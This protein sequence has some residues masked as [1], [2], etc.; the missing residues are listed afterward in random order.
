V[1]KG[2]RSDHLD[3]SYRGYRI[4]G[5]G[6]TRPVHPD[7]DQFTGVGPELRAVPFP[8]EQTAVPEWSALSLGKSLFR[9]VEKVGINRMHPGDS[10][11]PGEA[12]CESVVRELKDG[13][14]R[15]R[16]DIADASFERRAAKS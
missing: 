16:D 5:T 7:R 8:A 9:Q 12:G 2:W 10:I 4:G 6:C 14:S 15:R 11:H 1:K 3:D 13:D